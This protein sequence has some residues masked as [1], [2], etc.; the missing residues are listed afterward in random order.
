[1]RV[2]FLLKH[3]Q[4]PKDLKKKGRQKGYQ[5]EVVQRLTL[6]WK[7]C[8]RICSKH[9]KPFLPEIV[10]V[11]ERQNEVHLTAETKA[12][13]LSMICAT[14]NR[15]SGPAKFEHPHGLSTTK[16]ST[17][18]KKPFQSVLTHPERIKARLRQD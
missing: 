6:T 7:I 5:V 9:L 2:P 3:R 8:E 13:L 11:L 14:I 10:S 15:C 17:L 16:P 12:L 4:K 18:L 1:L